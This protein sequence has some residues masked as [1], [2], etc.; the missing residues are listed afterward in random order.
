MSCGTW[1]PLGI[2]NW[3]KFKLCW[4]NGAWMELTTSSKVCADIFSCGV[5]VKYRSAE[6][7]LLRFG[8]LER[9]GGKTWVVLSHVRY[10][11]KISLVAFLRRILKQLYDRNDSNIERIA[12]GSNLLLS[13]FLGALLSLHWKC[14]SGAHKR[15]YASLL[16]FAFLHWILTVLWFVTISA[17]KVF[18]EVDNTLNKRTFRECIDAIIK[19]FPEEDVFDSLIHFLTTSVE[20]S[21]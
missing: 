15:R 11:R 6:C 4:T 20:V 21:F 9:G 10:S 18:G 1:T 8:I 2:W 7:V 16:L 13:F 19:S 12:L 5:V 17:L 14:F 3:M